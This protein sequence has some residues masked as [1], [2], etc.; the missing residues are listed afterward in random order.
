M[1]CREGHNNNIADA[2]GAHALE[3]QRI[4]LLSE[5]MQTGQ[6][7]GGLR[8]LNQ[9]SE[10]C[11]EDALLMTFFRHYSSALCKPIRLTGRT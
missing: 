7:I 9:F 6:E 1:Q 4:R 5:H 8:L 3:T 10:K 2:Y 11:A